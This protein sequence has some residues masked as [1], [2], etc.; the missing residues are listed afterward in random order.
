MRKVIVPAF[1]SLDGV[2]QSPGS[3]DEDTAGGFDLGGWFWSYADE[4]T[5]AMEALFQRPFELLL[6]RRTYD[7]F[8]AFWP[9][10]EPD[11][12][13]RSTAELFNRTPKHVATHHPDSLDWA[14]SRPLGHDVTGAVRALKHS[15]GPDLLTQGSGALAQQLLASDLVDELI[16]V[17]VP[18]LLGRGK[19]LFD[20]RARPTAFRL[21]SSTTSSKGNVVNHYVREGELRIASPAT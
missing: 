15:D 4:A 6:G 14:P 8:A 19:R 3:P 7:V 20:E 11:S 17:V 12:P 10:V 18:I 16:L 1:I 2:I 13:L 5:D 9:Q 21:T